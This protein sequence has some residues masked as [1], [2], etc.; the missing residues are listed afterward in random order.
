MRIKM[1]S[2]LFNNT[3]YVKV[4]KNR[5]VLRHI[6]SGKS[7]TEISLGEFTT[8]RLLVGQFSEADKTLRK[9]MKEITH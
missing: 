1:F 6:E 9:G 8:I 7:I 3:L 5:F 4:F 2:K